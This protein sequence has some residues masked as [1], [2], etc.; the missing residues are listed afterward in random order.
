MQ[1][2]HHRVAY[3]WRVTFDVDDKGDV[4][5]DI[6]K[7]DGASLWCVALWPTSD[8]EPRILASDARENLQA[9]GSRDAL[10]L[11]ITSP[12][13]R[14]GDTH[15]QYTVG[16]KWT[17]AEAPKEVRLTWNGGGTTVFENEVFT[18]DEATP[19]FAYYLEHDTV[20]PEFELRLI[21]TISY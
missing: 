21:D 13:P 20:P 10:T 5:R 1:Q 18:A 4:D 6:E 8:D 14:D 11:A 17:G 12:E 16:K 7:I 9:A 19:I 3:N 2:R 15:S